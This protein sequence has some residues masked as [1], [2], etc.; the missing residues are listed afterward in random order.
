ML[1]THPYDSFVPPKARFL[2][3]GSFAVKPEPGCNWFYSSKR[4][5]FWPIL[6]RIYGLTLNNKKSRQHLFTKLK[7]AVTDIIFQCERQKNNNSDMNLTNIVYNTEGIKKILRHN[8]IEKIYFSSRYV[9]NMFKRIFKE[10]SI[11]L[12]TLPS[13]SPRYAAM[14]KTEKI[15]RYKKLLPSL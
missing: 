2:L 9:E 5:Q 14:S 12:I 15:A 8:R 10:T 6:E 11:E 7:I 1:E 3:L 4:N 13:P